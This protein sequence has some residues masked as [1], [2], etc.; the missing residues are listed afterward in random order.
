[1][2]PTGS[3]PR[4]SPAD[5]IL[6]ADDVH[7]GA[8]IV[9]VVIRMTASPAPGSASGPPRPRFWFLP[10]KHDGLHRR[11]IEPPEGAPGTRLCESATGVPR[12][13]RQL[14][15]PPWDVPLER[16]RRRCGIFSHLRG[17]VR[18][19]GNR[20]GLRKNQGTRRWAA[21][22]RLD[23]CRRREVRWPCQIERRASGFVPCS[24]GAPCWPWRCWAQT[25]VNYS[26]VSTNLI[27]QQARRTAEERVRNVERAARLARPQDAEAFRAILDELRAEMSDQNRRPCVGPR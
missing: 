16:P 1:M 18:A 24:P 20:P 12:T 6:A 5:R 3:C 21:A 2:T 27:R 11:H 23:V 15:P 8:A 26:Y 4:I 17:G 19:V 14:R 7:V 22:C 10:L 13:G 25:I 9:V